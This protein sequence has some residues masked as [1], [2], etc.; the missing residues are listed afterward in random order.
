MEKKF[1]DYKIPEEPQTY[2]EAV[3]IFRESQND[4]MHKDARKGIYLRSGLT[5]GIGAAASLVYGFVNHDFSLA[6][7]IMSAA[8]TLGG[9]FLLPILDLKKIQKNAEVGKFS[10]DY[11]EE[12]IINE[13][14]EYIKVYKQYMEEKIEG[15]KK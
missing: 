14:K 5:V 6:P 1:K 11:S 8:L 12:D 9:G 13:A 2:E 3:K 7:Y 4:E 15:K 10:S